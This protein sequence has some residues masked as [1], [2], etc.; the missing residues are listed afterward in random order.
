MIRLFTRHRSSLLVTAITLVVAVVGQG[1]A[2]SPAK[3]TPSATP[4]TTASPGLA[5]DDA[6]AQVFASE[7]DISLAEAKRRLGW[8][9][10]APDVAQALEGEPFFGGV[11]IDRADGD[12]RTIGVAGVATGQIRAR[13][14]RA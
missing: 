12:R 8:Q 5:V 14:T 9:T 11:W 4:S 2:S 13:V 7:R 6:E 1:C 10:L 3:P